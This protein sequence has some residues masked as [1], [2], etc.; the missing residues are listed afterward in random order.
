MARG[1]GS[2][3][4]GWLITFACLA[5]VGLIGTGVLYV[6]SSGAHKTRDVALAEKQKA[7]AAV[8]NMATQVSIYEEIIDGKST[9]N[10]DVIKKLE[11]LPALTGH[12]NQAAVTQKIK[13]FQQ[14]IELF[15]PNYTEARSLSSLVNYL[16]EEV[17][18]KN[19]ALVDE[20][21][22]T[23]KMQA[24]LAKDIEENR[25]VAE[26]AKIGQQKA[27]ADLTEE[28]ANF[29]K[30][31]AEANAKSAEVAKKLDELSQKL[32]QIEI[33]E[34]KVAE[35]DA[36][37]VALRKQ[38]EIE[39]AKTRETDAD[40]AKVPVADVVFANQLAD[41]ITINRGLQDGVR[42]QMTFSVYGKDETNL[43]RATPK[44]S[45]EVVQVTGPN[46]SE[47]RI[48]SGK[49]RDPIV[50]GDVLYTPA[51]KPGQKVHFALG[52][53]MDLNGDGDTTSDELET[54]RGLIA[55]NGGVVDSWVEIDGTVKTD[56]ESGGM[57]FYTRFFVVGL[58]PRRDQKE[59]VAGFD[60]QVDDFGVEKINIGKLLDYMGYSVKRAT[61]SI[62]S[63]P[64]PVIERRPPGA[65]LP[66]NNLPAPNEKEAPPATPPGDDPFT[67]RKPP[68]EAPKKPVD[69]G[70]D[71]FAD[72]K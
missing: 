69:P 12:P 67:E 43:A 41:T 48:I 47:C 22:K 8:R 28:R 30:Q 17:N 33:A 26:Q 15:G 51:W 57:G 70:A 64:T 13:D 21:N 72:P 44:A 29:E 59:M 53:N 63:S 19:Q 14:R 5:L 2:G 37:L 34:R 32:G 56:K 35:K 38:L 39:L 10:A 62:V 68:E 65:G 9:T 46:T 52:P 61:R 45:V 40:L 36:E 23:A 11:Q 6:D 50:K 71:P 18:R 4:V 55:L 60:K 66:A 16:S 58:P 42:R 24:D 31:R 25:N 27:E 3:G 49:L 20:Q 1:D 54:L 7:D